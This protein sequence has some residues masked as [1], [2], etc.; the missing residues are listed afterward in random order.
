MI[1]CILSKISNILY[2]EVLDSWYD[3]D[4]DSLLD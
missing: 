1:A 4:E 3:E 2:G